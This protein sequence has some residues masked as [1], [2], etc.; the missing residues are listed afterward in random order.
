[1]HLLG[2]GHRSE[3]SAGHLPE[4]EQGEESGPKLDNEVAAD[5]CHVVQV[6]RAL[7]AAPM[8][9]GS[10]W[11]D[12]WQLDEGFGW[13]IS[14]WSK[15]QDMQDVVGMNTSVGS[16]LPMECPT[17]CFGQISSGS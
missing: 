5:A 16:G 11:S 15:G 12:K 9:L 8:V 6:G 3:H 2:A 1:M 13:H 10:C 4:P 14:S 7:M 17:T